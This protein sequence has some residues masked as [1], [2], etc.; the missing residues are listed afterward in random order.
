MVGQG[1]EEEAFMLG[2]RWRRSAVVAAT[3]SGWLAPS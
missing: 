3:G 1:E 2:Q